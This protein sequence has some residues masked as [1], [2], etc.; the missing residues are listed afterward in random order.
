MHERVYPQTDHDSGIAKLLIDVAL[1][2]WDKDAFLH[3]KYKKEF[4]H[5][6]Y[7]LTMAMSEAQ[8]YPGKTDRL[9]IEERVLSKGL[10]AYH[11]HDANEACKK[12]WSTS[13]LSKLRN[14]IVGLRFNHKRVAGEPL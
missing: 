1:A 3:L 2:K 11:E 4:G 7:D 14:A 6:F 8:L 9:R 5:F 12:P 13:W 10:C